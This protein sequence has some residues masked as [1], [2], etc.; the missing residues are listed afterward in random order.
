MSDDGIAVA[1]FRYSQI[2][3]RRTRAERF[4]ERASNILKTLK[5]NIDNQ[6]RENQG[7]VFEGFSRACLA[8]A[9]LEG[10]T[11]GSWI[12]DRLEKHLA[13]NSCNWLLHRMILVGAGVDGKRMLPF[14]KRTIHEVLNPTYHPTSDQSYLAVQI[15]A[16]LFYTNSPTI[17][18]E[19]FE[20]NTETIFKEDSRELGVL[21][22]SVRWAEGDAVDTWFRTF[23][24]SDFSE[25]NRS[26]AMQALIERAIERSEHNALPSLARDS[27]DL[28]DLRESEGLWIIA[29]L[30]SDALEDHPEIQTKI[31]AEAYNAPTAEHAKRWVELISEM[32]TEEGVI[33]V[34]DLTEKWGESEM[35][36][37]SSL[38][39][40]HHIGGSMS[41]SGCFSNWHRSFHQSPKILNRLR[42]MSTSREEVL[43]VHA[44]KAL[45]WL[46]RERLSR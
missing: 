37:V 30:I 26:F 21:I 1:N 39:P 14:V 25:A 34:F 20:E 6:L 5:Q 32:G 24:S 9:R 27:M 38:Y 3:L 7:E 45:Y 33:I 41:F 13:E 4:N 10:E 36:V 23:L 18:I 8:I 12:M 19:V 28:G 16:S 2:Y 44:S 46:E 43:A 15:L 40:T 22:R 31:F 29:K 11:S 35:R 17:A 42:K